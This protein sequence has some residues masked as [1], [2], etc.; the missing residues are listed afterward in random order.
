[1]NANKLGMDAS[2]VVQW[3]SELPPPLQTHYS[4]IAAKVVEFSKM[5]GRS[6]NYKVTSRYQQLVQNETGEVNKSLAL[7]RAIC[8]CMEFFDVLELI[9]GNL[10]AY[11]VRNPLKTIA[12]HKELSRSVSD[13]R[14]MVILEGTLGNYT[15]PLAIKWFKKGRCDV[16]HE[17]RLYQAIHQLDSSILPWFSGNYRVWNDPVLV[18]RIKRVLEGTEDE[19]QVGITL[20][21]KLKVIHKVC[22]H[23]DIKPANIVK[24]EDDSDYYLIDY[25][26]STP[27]DDVGTTYHNRHVYTNG[28]YR[29]GWKSRTTVKTD[30]LELLYTLRKIQLDRQDRSGDKRSGFKGA[31]GR[32]YS[33]VQKLPEYPNEDAY[34][35]LADALR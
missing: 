13:P 5:L 6:L 15:A 30:L 34:D 22:I 10:Y 26:Q 4:T 1:M 27:I 28:Y 29:D 3:W 19:C 8:E 31:L 25:G 12:I 2:E 9:G 11:H 17:I 32:Y 18:V 16:L 21:R 33:I 23:C 35:R 14:S 7:N 24:E 20:L